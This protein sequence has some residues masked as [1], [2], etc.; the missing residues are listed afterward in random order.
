MTCCN[1]SYPGQTILSLC[2]DNT[3]LMI[4]LA[5][6]TES[7]WIRLGKDHA[8]TGLAAFSPVTPPPSTFPDSDSRGKTCIVETSKKFICEHVSG[9]QKLEPPL[10]LI[11]HWVGTNLELLA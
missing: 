2:R 11:D 3:V 10:W 1:C 4:R 6:S 7:T 9:L 5:L 8:A